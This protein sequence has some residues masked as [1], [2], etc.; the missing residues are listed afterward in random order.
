LTGW[1]AGL[2]GT[3]VVVVVGGGESGGGVVAWLE[4][5]IISPVFLFTI[6]R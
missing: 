4:L 1:G 6:L 3:V 5:Q 2:L